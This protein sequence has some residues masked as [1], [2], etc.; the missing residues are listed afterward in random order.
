MNLEEFREQ[1]TRSPISLIEL[2]CMT[3]NYLD[4]DKDITYKLYQNA[5]SFIEA[6]NAFTA[7]LDNA[8]IEL[9]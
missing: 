7:T 6:Y 1:Y 3:Y 4:L 5:S 9:G 8:S 2:A